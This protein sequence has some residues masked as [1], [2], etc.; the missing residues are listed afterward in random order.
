VKTI[1]LIGGMSWESTVDY[2][3]IL[4]REIKKKLGEPHSA[5]II[6]YSVDFADIEKMQSAGEWDKL[7]KK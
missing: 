1:G 3:K 2:Y 5:E 7:S 6:M 4:N